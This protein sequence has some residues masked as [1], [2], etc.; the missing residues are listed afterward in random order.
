MSDLL[1]VCWT[2]TWPDTALLDTLPCPTHCP[3][4][5]TALP[6]ESPVFHYLAD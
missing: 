3:A 1:T 6:C 4:R 2:V 5:N